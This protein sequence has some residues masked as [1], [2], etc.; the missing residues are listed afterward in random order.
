M[1][2]FLL[3]ISWTIASTVTAFVF[4]PKFREMN[5]TSTYEVF[6]ILPFD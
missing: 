2:I 5:C 6:V 1:G 3:A 4:M